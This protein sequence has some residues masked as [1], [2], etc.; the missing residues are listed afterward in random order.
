MI[1]MQALLALLERL[2]EGE[3]GLVGVFYCLYPGW[4]RG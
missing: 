3:A 1:I 2:R 4:D